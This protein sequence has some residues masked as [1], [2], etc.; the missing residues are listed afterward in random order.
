M[1]STISPSYDKQLCH[2]AVRKASQQRPTEAA[3]RTFTFHRGSLG[4]LFVYAEVHLLG[5]SRKSQFRLWERFTRGIKSLVA[6]SF[7][8]Q[9]TLRTQNLFAAIYIDVFSFYEFVVTI[10]KQ[11]HEGALVFIIF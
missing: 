9:R 11:G 8:Y 6:F 10:R 5:E 2:C 7:P 3:L 1:K 4:S